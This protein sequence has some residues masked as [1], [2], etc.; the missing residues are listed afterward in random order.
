MFLHIGFSH[1]AFNAWALF[2]LG[3]EVE[4]FY[5]PVWFT[6][7]YLISGLG[8]NL[9]YYLFGSDTLSA[10]ASGAV[11]GLIGSEAAFFWLNR[12][13][14]GQIG[15]QR[16]AN[17]AVL[18]GINLIFGFTVPGINNLAHLGGLVSG[19]VMGLALAPR[20][21]FR[22]L[23][24]PGTPEHPEPI[25]TRAL[26][27]RHPRFVRIAAVALIALSALV[28]LQVGHEQWAGSVDVLRRQAEAAFDQEDFAGAQRLLEQALELEPDDGLTLFNLG[29]AH[30]QQ[31]HVA[32]SVT[33]FE[34]ALQE[35]P[36]S[37]DVWFWLGLTYA[38]DGRLAEARPW[39]ENV[40]AQESSGP[41]ADYARSVLDTLP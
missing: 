18:I 29:L 26:F 20:Y 31:D 9:A 16:L 34:A 40:L 25:M 2:S 23:T 17:L 36:D 41:R 6:A 3:R 27:D 28:I 32:Q 7:I 10:G 11:F 5:G 12:D 22:L 37:V 15:R 24:F 39:L 13:L 35:L 14:F 4:A 8:G 33:A 21:R 30:V 1:L 38:M 19:A